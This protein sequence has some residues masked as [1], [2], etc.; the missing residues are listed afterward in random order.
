M[1]STTTMALSTNMPRAST[2]ENSTT[3]FKVTSM[4]ARIM[5]ETSML[6]GMATAT[7]TALRPPMNRNSTSSTSTRAAMM[8][9]SSSLTILAMRSDWSFR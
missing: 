5:N 1:F 9:F 3:K 2:R 4:E 8:L 6:K 7:K